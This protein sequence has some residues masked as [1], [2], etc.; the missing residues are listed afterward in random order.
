MNKIM[1]LGILLVFSIFVLALIA[2]TTTAG[3][4]D[5]Y[6]ICGT[7]YDTDGETIVSGAT[8]VILNV[9][10][11]ESNDVGAETITGSAI[12]VTT[13]SSGK[14]TFELLNLKSGYTVGDTIRVTATKSGVSGSKSSTVT[15]GTWGAVVDVTLGVT[16]ESE[17]SWWD[18]FI[19]WLLSLLMNL[20]FWL[21]LFLLFLFICY[22][23]FSGGGKKRKRS[24]RNR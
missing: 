5:P 4:Q 17:S 16:E 21:L 20:W 14:Y 6:T 12:T 24:K 3:I 9:D 19:D 13:D 18:S 2:P 22:L 7:V 23:L 11:G 1:K 15:S 10:T 8:V